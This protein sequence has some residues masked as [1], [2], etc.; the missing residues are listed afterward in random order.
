MVICEHA[1]GLQ[2]S[3]DA[4]HVAREGKAVVGQDQELCGWEAEHG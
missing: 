2:D 3:G 1:G 4:F